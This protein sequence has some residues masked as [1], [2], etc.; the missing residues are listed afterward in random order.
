MRRF[1]LL[2][3]GLALLAGVA[4]T[5]SGGRTQAATR[6]VIT[7]L[8]T[9]EA[10]AINDQGQVVGYTESEGGHAFLWENGKMRDLGTLGGYYINEIAINNDGQVAGWD[11]TKGRLG[12]AFL[13]EKGKMRNLGTLP[14]RTDSRAVAINDPGQVV[15]YAGNDLPQD[16]RAFLGEKGKMHDLGTLGGPGSWAVAINDQGQVVG[17]SDDSAPGGYGHRRAFLWEDGTMRKLGTLGGPGS[18][19]VAITDDGRVVGSAFTK[20]YKK[21]QYGVRIY[22]ERAFLWQDGKMR[23]LGAL[24]EEGGCL[25]DLLGCRSDAVAINDQG[26]VVGNSVTGGTKSGFP[27]YHAFLWEN[28]KMRDLG[29]LGGAESE[30]VAINDQ[31]QIIGTADTKARDKRGNPMRHAFV[32]QNGKMIDLGTL[33]GSTECDAIA[34]NNGGT[35]VGTCYLKGGTR[36]HA[37]LWTLKRG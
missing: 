13:W 31:G 23:D 17:I 37:V 26:Q 16:G 15:G 25:R 3:A 7:D 4:A 36:Q 30:A 10:V 20:A 19:P 14:G 9:G 27:I 35:I 22:V 6:W 2:V 24:S 33:P 21:N 34:I 29:T 8:G 18:W 1:A 32:W 11:E 12:R 5:V 28:G